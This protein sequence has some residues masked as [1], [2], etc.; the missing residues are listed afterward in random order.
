MKEKNK[1]L[2]EKTKGTRAKERKQR[3]RGEMQGEDS[4]KGRCRREKSEVKNKGKRRDKG[5]R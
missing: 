3:L 4:V 5:Q 1:G 2:P